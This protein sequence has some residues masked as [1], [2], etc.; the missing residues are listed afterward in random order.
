MSEFE[1]RINVYNSSKVGHAN[2]S[3]YESDQHVYTIGANIRMQVPLLA[4]PKIIPFEPDDG[5]YQD[6][7]AFHAQ[8]RETG[9]VTSAAVPITDSQY[10]ELINSARALEGQ[11]FNYSVFT[12]ACIELVEDFYDATGI[13][14]SLAISLPRM[15]VPDRSCG[16]AYQFQR[17]LVWNICLKVSRSTCHLNLSYLNY[18]CNQLPKPSFHQ[19]TFHQLHRAM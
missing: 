19:L 6:E 9:T 16:P 10:N 17:I 4:V 7:T 12:E 15:S 1:L 3:F 14:A 18:H 8:A 11:T 5:I 2:V 13:L